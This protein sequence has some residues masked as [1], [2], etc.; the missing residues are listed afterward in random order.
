M[1]SIR[2]QLC[3]FRLVGSPDTPPPIIVAGGAAHSAD[4]AGKIGD[5]LINFA[6][7]PSIVEQFESSGGPGKPKFI[8]YNVCYDESEEHA[9]KMVENCP[10]GDF[11]EARTA[12]RQGARRVEH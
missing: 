5:G 2:S 10:R 1:T 7:E 12:T 6:P 8:Q 11:I 3:G 4:L 9:R